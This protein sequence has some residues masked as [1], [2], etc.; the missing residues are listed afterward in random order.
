MK[1]AY[2]APEIASSYLSA[3]VDYVCRFANRV[4]NR[5]SDANR[6]WINPD[7]LSGSFQPILTSA[8]SDLGIWLQLSDIDLTRKY[9]VTI[10]N[11][12]YEAI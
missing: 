3:K 7:Y 6:P 8:I 12:P 10:C 1:P 9:N 5:D 11:T 2:S 4:E